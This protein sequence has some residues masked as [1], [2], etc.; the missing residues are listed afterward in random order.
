MTFVHGC[1]LPTKPF[2]AP[3]LRVRATWRDMLVKINSVACNAQRMLRCC[4]YFQGSRSRRAGC[5]LLKHIWCP[6]VAVDVGGQKRQR[7][8]RLKNVATVAA[9]SRQQFKDP[10]ALVI[11]RASCRQC[12]WMQESMSLRRLPRPRAHHYAGGGESC[13]QAS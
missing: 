7:N 8:T 3:P 2:W 13:Y 1:H 11:L 6:F 4:H 9:R 10:C 5:V 12:A